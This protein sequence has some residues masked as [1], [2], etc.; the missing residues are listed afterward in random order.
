MKDACANSRNALSLYPFPTGEVNLFSKGTK[1]PYTP[2]HCQ[3]NLGS[4]ETKERLILPCLLILPRQKFGGM[5][6]SYFALPLVQP[7]PDL[8]DAGRA[9][10]DY[11]I[12]FSHFNAIEFAL[13]NGGGKLRVFQ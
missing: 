9:I 2:G 1:S 11:N 8:E 7:A 5:E 6:H 4:S 10:G 3:A 12:S 13:E